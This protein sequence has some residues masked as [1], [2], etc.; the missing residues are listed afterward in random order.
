MKTKTTYLSAAVPLTKTFEIENGELKKTS[1]PRIIDVTSYEETFETIEEFHGQLVTH[2]AQGHSFLKGNVSRPLIT[3]SRAKSTDANAPTTILLLDVDGLKSVKT[4]GEFL[5]TLGLDDVDY[6]AQ[7]S[8]SMGIVEGRGLSVH[9]FMLLSKLWP[10]SM[11]K[12]WLISKNLA[13]SELRSNLSLTRT[14]NTLRWGLDVTTCQN[15]KLIYIAPPILGP[16]VADTF[17]LDRIQLVKGAK[18]SAELSG[19]IPSAEANRIAMDKII[20]ELR[21]AAGLP[22][23]KKSPVK[24]SHNVEYQPNPDR[25]AVSSIKTERGF[26]YV[27]ING[28]DSW[29]YYH[30]ENNPEFIYN[31]KGEPTYKTSEL[32]PEY[33]S[34]VRDQQNIPTTSTDGMLYLA[35]RDF[36]TA[37]YYN[38]VWS[39]KDRN[40]NLQYAKSKDQ[41]HDFLIQHKQKI[42]AAIPDW[43]VIFNPQS[44][45]TVDIDNRSINRFEPSVYMSMEHRKVFEVPPT[46][47]QVIFNAVG[48]DEDVFEHFMNSLACIFQYRQKSETGWVFHGVEGTGKGMMLTNIL[49]PIFGGRH[50]QPVR[51][52]QL[53]T[54]FNEFMEHSLILWVDE[55]KFGT[56]NNM[57]TITGDLKNYITESEIHIRKMYTPGYKARNYTTIILVGNEDSIVHVPRGSRRWNVGVYQTQKLTALGSTLEMA[58]R[59]AEELTDFAAY[60]ATRVADRQ[61]ARTALN[62]QAKE[63]LVAEGETGLAQAA[64]ALLTGDFQYFWDARPNFHLKPGGVPSVAKD[65]LNGAY[66]GLLK[67]IVQGKRSGLLREE[68]HLLF[69]YTIGS[70]PTAPNK[71]ASLIKHHKVVLGTVWRD[72]KSVRGLA[73]D[74]KIDPLITKEFAK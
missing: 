8:S 63:K 53:D 57:D 50:V 30:P 68:I 65:M 7:Y 23:R 26:T 3:E 60:L 56:H 1:H 58:E 71:F 34:E 31:F 9:I 49:T 47:R 35:F 2:A 16:G 45:I 39:E 70:M 25:A 37:M 36:R 61:V 32:L 11:L 20:D 48:S 59:I 73:V 19:A 13:I 44:D 69:E 72:K 15:D 27:N 12:E 52:R 51:M 4:V 55:A 42:P 14:N 74:W 54:Q 10:A 38:A 40:L 46:I 33:W 24:T 64:S 17:G 6:I 21:T 18:R 67:E 66:L 5:R 41:L 22:E 29:A 28:G 43:N 62:N